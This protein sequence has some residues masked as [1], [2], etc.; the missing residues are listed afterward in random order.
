MAAEKVSLILKDLTLIITGLFTVVAV[1]SAALRAPCY[2]L[3][4]VPQKPLISPIQNNDHPPCIYTSTACLTVC[5][6]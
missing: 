1:L 3:N 2:Q 5:D 6:L 4:Q